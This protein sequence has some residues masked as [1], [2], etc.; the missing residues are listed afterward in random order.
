MTIKVLEVDQWSSTAPEIQQMSL[1]DF[2][3]RQLSGNGVEAA[4]KIFG[5]RAWVRE[6]DPND[7]PRIGNVWF[8]EV[9]GQL[10]KWRWNYDSSD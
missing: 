9:D 2:N 4:R 6:V 10:T 7:Q 3:F 8:R 5:G 1:A